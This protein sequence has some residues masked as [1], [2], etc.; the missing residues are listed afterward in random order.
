MQITAPQCVNSPSAIQASELP[1]HI[2]S[3]LDDARIRQLSTRTIQERGIYLSKLVWFLK[4]RDYSMF[5]TGAARDFFTYLTVA[6]EDP[7][8]RWGDP[9]QRQ[10]LRPI[11]IRSYYTQYKKSPLQATGYFNDGV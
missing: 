7:S 3:H 2:K 1:G 4:L 11:T 10:P 6:H 5:D 9:R 8:G